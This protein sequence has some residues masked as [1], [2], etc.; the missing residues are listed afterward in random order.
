MSDLL[1]DDRNTC[2]RCN[3]EGKTYAGQCMNWDQFSTCR[4]CGGSGDVPADLL[5]ELSEWGERNLDRQGAGLLSARI[6]QMRREVAP[7]A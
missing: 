6:E 5:A 7:D 3:G 2:S 1:T 4:G